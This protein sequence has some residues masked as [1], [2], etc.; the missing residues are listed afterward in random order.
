MHG[1]NA[2]PDDGGQDDSF[3]TADRHTSVM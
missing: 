1:A 2:R 3:L